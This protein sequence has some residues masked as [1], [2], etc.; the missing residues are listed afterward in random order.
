MAAKKATKK[1][2]T[3]VAENSNDVLMNSVRSIGIIKP[4]FDPSK[5]DF[6]PP[7]LNILGTGFWVGEGVFVTCAHVVDGLLSGPIEVVGALVVG[8][9][10]SPYLKASISI[11]DLEHDLAVLQISKKVFHEEQKEL[12]LSITQ[13]KE[14][15]GANVSFAGYPL[16]NHLLNEDHTPIFSKGVIAHTS[17][18]ANSIRKEIKISGSVD[19]GF[20]GSPVIK[21]DGQVVGVVSNKPQQSQ[22]IFNIISWEHLQ[23][24]VDLETS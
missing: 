9:N 11:L 22:S 15:I 3:K 13:S 14:V 7:E 2:T 23:K 18:S 1:T 21:E 4:A 16:G 19:G 17:S 20:S 5:Q 8:G 12:C 10:R 24:I 6:S